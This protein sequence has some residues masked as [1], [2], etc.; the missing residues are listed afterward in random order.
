MGLTTGTTVETTLPC[1][2]GEFGRAGCFLKGSGLA[3][4]TKHQRRPA[5]LRVKSSCGN[6]F[7][8]T[9]QRVQEIF[10]PLLALDGVVIAV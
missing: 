4:Q 10:C 3:H 2:A 9:P 5:P 7:Q 6:D 1:N 8:F